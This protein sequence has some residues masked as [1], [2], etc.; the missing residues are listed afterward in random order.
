MPKFEHEHY[1]GYASPSAC[2][3]HIHRYFLWDVLWVKVNDVI[4]SGTHHKKPPCPY[5]NTTNDTNGWVS[6][7]IGLIQLKIVK[8]NEFFGLII[9]KKS[10]LWEVLFEDN[11]SI[12]HWQATWKVECLSLF[13]LGLG[14]LDLL[15]NF[16]IR[17]RWFF[18]LLRLTS[19]LSVDYLLLNSFCIDSFLF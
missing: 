6:L 3:N 4:T 11:D 5:K 9:I 16:I 2:H 14:H 10:K 12:L 7:N 17:F 15:G 18:F 13:W 1:V 19:L 8:I